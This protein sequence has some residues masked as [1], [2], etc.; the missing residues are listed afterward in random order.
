MWTIPDAPFLLGANLP[1]SAAPRA[2]G[3]KRRT[4]AGWDFGPGPPGWW[5]AEA[6]PLPRP[7]S[8][9]RADLERLRAL[10]VRDVRFF[11]LANGVN[12]PVGEPLGHELDGALPPELPDAFVVDFDGLLAACEELGMR[13]WPSLL[14]FEFF[15]RFH[16]YNERVTSGGRA[17]LVF[18]PRGH[19]RSIERFLEATLEPLLAAARARSGSIGAF[20]VVN[21]PDWVVTRL[22]FDRRGGRVPSEWMGRLLSLASRRIAEAGQLATVGFCDADPRWL[23]RRD[24][25]EL[26]RLAARGSYVHQLHHYPGAHRPRRLSPHA[27][28]PIRP[29]VVGEMPTSLGTWGPSHNMRWK[30]PGLAE[31]NP[32]R[33]LRERLELVRRLGYP[34]AFV[35][36][37]N[38][39]DGATSWREEQGAQIR[40]FAD[41]LRAPVASSART[42]PRDGG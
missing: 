24:R 37:L 7:W 20:E 36:A 40:A 41:G 23:P 21:E 12:Y 28:L 5:S 35:W 27:E 31:A 10:G 13:L 38:S 16:R 33:F 18:G 22:P 30:D 8:E 17:P 15:G 14:S 32:R 25:R 34:G 4:R 11:L 1:W 9:T 19:E 3:E 42:S 39:E 29:C 6:S 2:D 26:M